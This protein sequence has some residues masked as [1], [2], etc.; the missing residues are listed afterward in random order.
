[1]SPYDLAVR[2]Y[3][4]ADGENQLRA[5]GVKRH[6]R[7]L[8]TLKGMLGCSPIKTWRLVTARRVCATRIPFCQKHARH[9]SELPLIFR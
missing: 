9:N 6:A 7:N 4:D 3:P 5:K 2:D 8:G 1:M